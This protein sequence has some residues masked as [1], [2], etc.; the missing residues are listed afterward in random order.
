[1]SRSCNR[2]AQVLSTPFRR[3]HETRRYDRFGMSPPRVEVTRGAPAG[4]RDWLCSKRNSTWDRSVRMCDV[5]T[6]S[7]SCDVV[8]RLTGTKALEILSWEKRRKEQGAG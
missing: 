8:R 6:A 4:L 7:T 2:A 3:K 1:M 5:R